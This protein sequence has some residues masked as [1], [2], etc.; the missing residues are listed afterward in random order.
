MKI[1]EREGNET[2][3]EL[4]VVEKFG[5]KEIAIGY[6]V[7]K[8]VYEERLPGLIKEATKLIKLHTKHE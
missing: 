7:A 3:N 6:A 4:F 2:H 1:I 8:H 5:G